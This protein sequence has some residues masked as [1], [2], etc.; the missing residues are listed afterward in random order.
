MKYLPVLLFSFV[1][2]FQACKNDSNTPTPPPPPAATNGANVS[3]YSHRYTV[4]DQQL[5]GQYRVRA[6]KAVDVYLYPSADIVKLGQE[7][8]LRGDAVLLDDI[9]DAHLL[10]KAGVLSPYNAGTFGDYVPSRYVDN[11]SYWAGT[12]RWTMSFIYR[13][14]TVNMV[15]MRKYG[16]ILA[17]AYQGRVAIAHPDSSGLISMTASMIAAHGEDPARIYLETLKKNLHA[18]P[19]GNDFEA[20][21][22]VLRGDADVALVNGSQFMRYKH[23]G[24]PELFSALD[25]LE[26]EIPTDTDGNNY[27]NITPIC[28]LNNGAYRNYA[29]NLVEFLTIQENQSMYAESQLEYPV[30]IF[31]EMAELLNST[32]NL[33]QGQ[34]ST[35]MTENQLDKAAALVEEI[36]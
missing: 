22:A 29:I 35:E 13:P 5:L 36:F 24:N 17:P 28:I 20:I 3:L 18:E 1:F 8:Q 23:S 30:N 32:F 27:F 2:F 34:I 33:P 6:N 7:G 4:Q 16:S 25:Q 11:E 9:Y 12:S 10:R 31:G 14:S 19:T 21:S 15:D 26:M